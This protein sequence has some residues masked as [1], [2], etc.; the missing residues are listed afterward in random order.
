M[1]KL[2]KVICEDC[3]RVFDGGPKAFFCP[4]C[5]AKHVK[6]AA[7]RSAKERNLSAIGVA[8]KKKARK[9]ADDDAESKID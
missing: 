5:R 8:A 1:S 3:E 9:E 7:R 2:G 6:E 4:E